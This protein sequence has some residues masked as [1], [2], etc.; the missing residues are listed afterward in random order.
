MGAYYFALQNFGEFFAQ[1]KNALNESWK[2]FNA[3]KDLK[4]IGR[5]TSASTAT[6]SQHVHQDE[7]KEILEKCL[8]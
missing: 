6:G 4:F 1:E 3:F 8:L 5:K 2:N 7:Q